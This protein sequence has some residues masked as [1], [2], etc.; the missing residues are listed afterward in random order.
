MEKYSAT[1]LDRSASLYLL[2]QML[3]IIII[4]MIMQP[5]F[6]GR[7]RA[8]L[9]WQ[10]KT[11]SMSFFSDRIKPNRSSDLTKIPA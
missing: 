8:N 7:R 2:A 3:I 10:Q 11:N 1:C 9:V 5:V 6:G 4:I